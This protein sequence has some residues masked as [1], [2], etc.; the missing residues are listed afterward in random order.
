MSALQMGCDVCHIAAIEQM[1]KEGPA[2][3]E[4]IFTPEE[5]QYSASQMHPAQHLAGF[6]AA[7]EALAKAVREP[8]LLGKYYR[9]VTVCHRENGM[10]GL[11]LSESLAKAFS[12]RGIRVADLSISHDGDY[13]VAAVLVEQKQLR[14]GQCSMSLATLQEQGIA[15]VLIQVTNKDGQNEYRCP[16]CIRGW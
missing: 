2:A 1:L 14:C 13:A 6:F 15:D 10:P 7:K 5:R 4:R 3:L 16:V 11:R 8:S 9:E 12:D